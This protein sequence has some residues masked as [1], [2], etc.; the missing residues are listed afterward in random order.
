M[1]DKEPQNVGLVFFP[2]VFFLDFQI[3]CPPMSALAFFSST[4]RRVVSM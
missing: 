3:R 1:I 4:M 2:I